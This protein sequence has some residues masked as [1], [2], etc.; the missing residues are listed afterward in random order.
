MEK[1]GAAE[2]VFASRDGRSTA[3]ALGTYGGGHVGFFGDVN[4]EAVRLFSLPHFHV[5]LYMKTARAN[6]T[7]RPE[8]S[9]PTP[10]SVTTHPREYHSPHPG[11]S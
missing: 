9:Q 7:Q 11:V 4:V 5:S 8:V 10:R 6:P 2:A 1:V 3:V